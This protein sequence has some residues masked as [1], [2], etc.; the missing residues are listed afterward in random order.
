MPP[1]TTK[2]KSKAK[3]DAKPAAAAPA[4]ADLATEQARLVELEAALAELVA[5]SDAA[6]AEVNR[7]QRRIVTAGPAG[8][9][10]ALAQQ[11][12]QTRLLEHRIRGTRAK[13]AA[14]RAAIARLGG[15]G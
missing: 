14:C 10:G 6:K 5:T 2:S 9:Q 1:K 15:A 11:G 13:I 4:N 7:L 12:Q 3:S 8:F